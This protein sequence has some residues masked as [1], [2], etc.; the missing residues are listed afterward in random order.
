[1][2]NKR[3]EEIFQYA[4]EELLFQPVEILMPINLKQAHVKHM[5]QYV[6]EPRVRPMGAG[7]ELQARRKDDTL[8]P[9]EISL[10]PLETEQGLLVSAAIRDISERRAIEQ[11]LMKFNEALE[12]QVNARTTEIR[13]I[14]EQLRQ[15]SARLEEAQEQERIRI[16]REIHDELGQQLTGLKMD[17]A[18][19]SKKTNSLDEAIRNKFVGLLS[20]L[21]QMVVTVR[22]ISTELRPAVLDDLGLMAAIEWH[23]AEF[24]KRFHIKVLLFLPP[25]DVTMPQEKA[26]GI[27]RVYQEALTN[28]ARHA[29]AASV[30]TTI[31]IND[32]WLLMTIADDGRGFDQQQAQAKKTLGLIGMKERIA[33]IGGRYNITGNTEK[34]TVVSVEVPL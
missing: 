29:N 31:R 8:F 25:D 24:E 27:F 19:L 12:Q 26:T 30:K 28:I 1:M 4:R 9:V 14:N 17:V 15:L 22:R 11:R 7:M 33:I 16:A 6:A 10:S 20:L 32:G 3:V 2:V 23:S 13:Q 21:D 34:G 18:W 5:Q